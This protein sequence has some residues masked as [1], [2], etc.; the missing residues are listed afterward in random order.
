MYPQPPY[1]VLIAGFLAAIAAGSA[2]SALLQQATRDWS[3]NPEAGSLED[4]RGFALKLPYITICVG[5]T[6]CLGAGIQ[7][8]GYSGAIAYPAGAV[9]TTLMAV[10]VWRQLGVILAQ[11]QAGG[12][13]ALDLDAY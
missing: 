1:V 7:L 3:Q 6:V 13:K 12:S 2:F 10:L 11:L 9:M 8:F 5:L 4:I